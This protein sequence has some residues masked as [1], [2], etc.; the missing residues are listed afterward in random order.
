MKNHLLPLTIGCIIAGAVVA[1][2]TMQKFTLT[3]AK[4]PQVAKVSHDEGN[5]QIDYAGFLKQ[6]KEIEPYRAKRRVDLKTFLKMASEPNTI[7]L[8]TRSKRAY[9]NVHIKGAKHLNFSDFTKTSLKEAIPNKDTRI[10]IYCNNNFFSEPTER[11][12]Q[13]KSMT[14]ALNIPTFI[15]LV[16]YG[17]KNVYEL[18]GIVAIDPKVMPL[19]GKR[20]P[21]SK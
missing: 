8:D 21:A 3:S 7:V 6:A 4:A 19:A 9:S 11:D 17:Y 5:A 1:G 16:G 12:L 13:S 14:L 15:N 2:E 10:L 20:F 18:K